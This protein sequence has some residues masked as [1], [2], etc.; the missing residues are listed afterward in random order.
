MALTLD[1]VGMT[2]GGRRV[3]DDVGA[4]FAPGRVTAVL[5]PNG[6]GK[7]TLAGV[8]AGLTRPDAGAAALDGQPVLAI[9]ARE[10][11]RRIGYLPQAAQVHWDLRV[12]ELVALGRLPHRGPF[13]APDEADRAAVAAALEATDT[14]R[15]M[16]RS[17]ATLSGGEAARVHLARVL[18]GTPDWIIADEPLEGL[19]PAHRL[20]VLD[21]LRAAASAG[22]GVVV[23][24]HD[25]S[26]A[27]RA[28]DD[29]LLLDGGRIV[30]AGPAAG[31]LTP[32]RLAAVYGVRFFVGRDGQGAPLLVPM[33]RLA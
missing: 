2:L 1:R 15:F 9:P 11:A 21:R 22:A 32:E 26:H 29:A 16:G 20:D 19:D 23:I 24:L 33:E 8:L 14:A 30:A 17:M 7:S 5:G 6:A 13:A 10:R 27:A 3:L 25:L 4:S 28:A 18:A 31:V 12:G